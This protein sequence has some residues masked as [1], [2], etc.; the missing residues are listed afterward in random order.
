MILEEERGKSGAGI[1]T[2]GDQP[3]YPA[4]E[5]E[6]STDHYASGHRGR[7]EL[8]SGRRSYAVFSEKRSHNLLKKG[9]NKKGGERKW[10][11]QTLRRS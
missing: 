1:Q 5:N 8:I 6:G 7:R 4:K 10:Q 9:K 11:K 2:V 3:E